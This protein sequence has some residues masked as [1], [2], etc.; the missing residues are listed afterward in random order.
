MIVN[1]YLKV[2]QKQ[3]EDIKEKYVEPICIIL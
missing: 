2:T 3:W 1:A